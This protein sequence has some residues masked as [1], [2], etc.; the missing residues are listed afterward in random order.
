MSLLSWTLTAVL[1]L[2]F[3]LSF[4]SY[5]AW[6]LLCFCAPALLLHLRDWCRRDKL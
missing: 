6:S 2:G 3:G 5:S 4:T 1:L